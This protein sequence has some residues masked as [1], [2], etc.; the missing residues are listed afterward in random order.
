MNMKRLF[1]CCLCFLIFLSI[2]TAYGQTGLYGQVKTE[3]GTP[4][5]EAKIRVGYK[6]HLIDEWK[7]TEAAAD[8]SGNYCIKDFPLD[9]FSEINE[10]EAQL[11]FEISSEILPA[12]FVSEN[13]VR[14][15]EYN[16]RPEVG[17]PSRVELDVKAEDL[18][19]SIVLNPKVVKRVA[20][21][22]TAERTKIP[23]IVPPTTAATP[24]SIKTNLPKSAQS[25]VKIIDN[26]NKSTAITPTPTADSSTVPTTVPSSKIDEILGNMSLGNLA[27]VTPEIITLEGSGNCLSETRNRANNR[28]IGAGN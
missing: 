18:P 2:Q 23:T 24:L 3:S 16:K 21:R 28:S 25:P 15:I 20:K 7:Y 12:P 10:L 22:T 4:I 8:K 13:F 27:F 1:I 17:L 11:S 9:L 14:N 19:E 26:S 6:F 5:S